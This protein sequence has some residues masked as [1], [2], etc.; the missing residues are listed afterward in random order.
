MLRHL[1]VKAIFHLVSM[2]V[3]GTFSGCLSGFSTLQRYLL[4]FLL[5]LTPGY[6]TAAPQVSRLSPDNGLSQGVVYS[7][8][9][10]DKGQLWL[11]TE[12]DL[13][14]YDG[15]S[16]EHLRSELKLSH[17][18]VWDFDFVTNH[19]VHLATADLGL[20]DVDLASGTVR[21]LQQELDPSFSR[22]EAISLIRQDNEQNRWYASAL[23]IYRMGP[24]HQLT[25][26]FRFSDKD[27]QEHYIRDLLRLDNRLIIATSMGL[28][29][30]DLPTKTLQEI[31]YLPRSASADQRNSKTLVLHDQHLLIGTVAGLYQLPLQALSEQ[32]SVTEAKTIL[33]EHNVWKL[34]LSRQ[35]ELLAGT[36][37]GFL[38][39]DLATGVVETLFQPGQTAYAYA[40]DTILDF[41]ELA[42]GRY[43]LASRGDGAYFLDLNAKGFNNI[44]NRT[45]ERRLSHNFVF[46]LYGSEAGLWIGT[47]NGLNLYDWQSGQMEQLLV[48]SDTAAPDSDAAIYGI[49]PDKEQPYLWLLTGLSLL[50]FD[51][52]EKQ[53]V[54]AGSGADA[55]F[56]Q[57]YFYSITQTATK[58]LLAFNGQG[59]FRIDAD[60]KVE[61]LQSLSA[62]LQAPEDAQWF[63]LNPANHNELLFFY[64]RAIWR[65]E[66]EQDRVSKVYQVPERYKDLVMFGEGMQQ[67]DQSLWLLISGLG[68]VEL[69]A[70]SLTEKSHF[71]SAE[72]PELTTTILYGLQRDQQGYLWMSSHSGLWRFNP[73]KKLVR[74]FTHRNG[75][76]YNEFNSSSSSFIPQQNKLVFGSQRG[77]TF[78]NPA[79]FISAQSAQPQLY[80][81]KTTLESRSTAAKA[82]P[83]VADEISLS[84][85]DF[86]LKIQL[87]TFDYQSDGDSRYHFDLSG[88]VELPDYFK[89]APQLALPNLKPGDYSV[90][91]T[92]FNAATEQSSKPALLKITVAYPPWRSPLA[93]ASYIAMLVTMALIWIGYRVRQRA[94]LMVQHEALKQLNNKLEL[95][96]AI[97]SSDVWEADL[98]E[99]HL[100]YSNRMSLVFSES[101][102]S[103]S[104]DDY[105]N[106]LH[107]ADRAGFYQ[108]WQALKAA[109]SLEFNC[110]YRIKAKSGDWLWFKDVGKVAAVQASKASK[111]YGLYTDIT[112]QKLTELE[113]EQL[114]HYDQIT[115]LPNRN[116]LQQYLMQEDS[117][118][119]FKAFIV[120]KLQQFSEVKSAFGDLAANS[121]L[122]QISSRLRSQISTPDLLIH[123]A[124]STFIVAL[125][126]ADTAQLA[127][128]SE[129]LLA[130]ASEPVIV[131]E[132]DITIP[133]AAG[134]ASQTKMQESAQQLL[135][136]AE[137]ALRVG[138]EGSGQQHL[139]Y[140]SGLLEQTRDKFIVQ[141]Q[142][143]E[144]VK[145]GQLLNYY[146]PIVNAK[147]GQLVGIE[148]LSRW[149]L[150]GNFVSP[151]VFI[152]IAEGIGIIDDIAFQS[153]ATACDDLHIL[154]ESGEFPYV[155]I[156]LTGAQLCSS[157]VLETFK[158]IVAQKA[159]APA[160]IK[161][162]ITESTLI[163]NQESAIRNMNELRSAGFQIF[164]DDFG[165]GYSSLK[166][167]QDFPLNAIKIDRSFVSNISNSTAVIDTII[168]LAE[169]LGVICI[170]EGVETSAER[171]YLLN[172]GCSFMQG[173]FY[174]KPVAIKELQDFYQAVQPES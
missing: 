113:L 76:A 161:L 32:S 13:D 134:T 123:A 147:T 95:S 155:S 18:V 48:H 106:L 1:S 46:G 165:T 35:A 127:V 4:L 11:S 73:M 122:L 40:D 138:K 15:T 114:S 20:L 12:S 132:R 137:L 44:Y 139:S 61:K 9:L 71:F 142:L 14:R 146:Q 94:L 172:K 28:Y 102:Q 75:L 68:L 72:S 97:A 23:R 70:Q 52:V 156:N 126:S 164:L 77:V 81:T 47:Q 39:I 79:E 85:D 107:P 173:Y 62:F 145:Q 19:N 37:A 74:Q 163:R 116:L 115:G 24:D 98:L 140:Q 3:S 121:V 34:K 67:L 89:S 43:W 169:S 42:E 131:Q 149:Q 90:R 117:G 10:D 151:D 51:T 99:D 38:K 26:E 6:L 103:Y 171:D 91:I 108:S 162:E 56:F 59:A 66:P 53:L 29:Q 110:T 105:L 64:Q 82:I 118:F 133:C 33:S 124:E 135:N 130:V 92:A 22:S 125:C 167:I 158:Q 30:Y 58:E 109:E 168:T 150:E 128:L 93:Y 49:Y 87:A 80:I 54:S 86:G 78:F 65:Y 148:L 21:Y 153:L 154:H 7:M 17:D 144:A 2:L 55:A 143:R 119:D 112:V 166:Y 152:P 36:N 31:H 174:S 27:P 159:I 25:E 5:I 129:R 45:G 50:K 83:V 160:D 84:H 170:A 88:P 69:D 141:Q 120:V 41:I 8:K 57:Q 136:Q 16:I 157:S 111:V 60:N 104:L 100:S 63:G 96:M 101:R